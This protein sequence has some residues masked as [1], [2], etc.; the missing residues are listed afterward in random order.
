M[1]VAVTESGPLWANGMQTEQS[2]GGMRRAVSITAVK[3]RCVALW[4]SKWGLSK[5]TTRL[6][7]TTCCCLLRTGAPHPHDANNP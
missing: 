6:V 4:R 1:W 3:Y 2:L 7:T 5:V